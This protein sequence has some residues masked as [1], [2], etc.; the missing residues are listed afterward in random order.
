MI[1]N[2][3]SIKKSLANCGEEITFEEI[4]IEHD[5]LSKFQDLNIFS[6]NQ[7]VD[8]YWSLAGQ[9]RKDIL[10]LYDSDGI[11]AQLDKFND[12]KIYFVNEMN[13]KIR[14]ISI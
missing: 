12:P 9:T 5:F 10:C 6:L 3:Q 8:N 11:Q 14:V 1:F 2:D 4:I 7:Y 13:S